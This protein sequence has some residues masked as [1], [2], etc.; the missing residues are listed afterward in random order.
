MRSAERRDLRD[1][2][3]DA[4]VDLRQLRA[5]RIE[6]RLDA[7]EIEPRHRARVEPRLH[8]IAR[9][10]EHLDV[11]REHLALRLQ[12]AQLEIGR[13]HL[14]AHRHQRVAQEI[15][16]LL[17]VR[18][19]G[20]DLPADRAP[21]IDL[22]RRHADAVREEV[23]GIGI[24][25]RRR[26]LRDV[27]LRARV[28]GAEAERRPELRLAHADAR[29]GRAHR[30]KRGRERLVV[31]IR[32]RDQRIKLRIAEQFP[33]ARRHRRLARDPRPRRRND[34]GRG[35]RIARR[36]R[37]GADLARRKRE[38]KRCQR[39]ATCEDTR[40]AQPSIMTP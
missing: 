37:I 8:H 30:T 6:L 31:R 5:R 10:R 11:L 16:L 4:R 20:L 38:N 18:L 17:G 12:R 26:E 33:P 35:R 40:S 22:P 32:T 27:R 28:L 3:G 36:R 19:R 2:A 23:V 1:R 21:E 9:L 25:A 34:G 15:D 14:R 29:V 13:A 7:R 39:T 24:D